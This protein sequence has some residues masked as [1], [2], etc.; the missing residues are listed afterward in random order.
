LSRITTLWSLVRQAHQAPA[1]GTTAARRELLERYGRAL[2]RYLLGATGDEDTADELMQ[3][4]ALRFLRGDFHRADP[5][6]GRFRDF[7]RTALIRLVSRHRRAQ[8]QQPMSLPDDAILATQEPDED[9]LDAE[10]LRTWREE[11]LT[12]T[13]ASLEQHQ[14]ETGRPFFLVLRLGVDH[15]EMRSPE[16]AAELSRQ[17]GKPVTAD[18]ARQALHRARVQFAT[19]LREEVAQT[20]DDSS[21]ERLTEELIHLDL[22]RY[23]ARHLDG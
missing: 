10:F 1:E 8:R 17:L 22:L 19:I 12:R 11:L 3:E 21:D 18:G 13:W 23:C 14:E 6:Q 7:V 16:L 9:V 20:L 2:R 5:D 4:F 15:P